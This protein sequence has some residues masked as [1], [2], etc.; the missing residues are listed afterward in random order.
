MG[1][2]LNDLLIRNVEIEG[3]HSDVRILGG[4]IAEIGPGLRSDGEVL[5]GAGGAL[6]PGLADHH[7]HLMG[8][9][10]ARCSV[11]LDDVESPGALARRLRRPGAGWLRATG[12]HENRA[13][14]L[15]RAALDRIVSDRPVRVQHQT[16][17]VWI[18][19]SAALALLDLADAPEGVDAATGRIERADAWLR[20]QI[21]QEAP[22]LA[23]LG[24]A[25][26][27]MG[28]T[29]VTD[30]SV[31]NDDAAAA[32]LAD[33]ATGGALP[34]RVTMMSGR[35]LTPRPGIAVGHVKILPDDH[36]LPTLDEMI[37]R[38]GDARRWRRGIAVHCVTAAELALTLAALETAG[39]MPGDRIEHGGVISAEAIPQLKR[40][41]LTVVTQSA[42]PYTRGDR[43]LAEVDRQEVGD[44]YRCASLLRAGVPVAGSSDAPYAT[45]DPWLAMRAAVTRRT[46]GGQAIGAGEAIDAR[47]A[48]A[49]YLGDASDPGGP[50]RRVEIGAVA[51]LCVL[52]MPVEQLSSEGVAATLVAGRIVHRG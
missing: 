9:A 32:L 28:V 11:A 48:L 14:A 4:R 2:C 16:G 41:G 24:A 34:Q 5:E 36:N 49:L 43:Y 7:I 39:A 25:L 22:D 6:I 47:A 23:Q 17:G 40:M 31:T 52:R 12:F 10:A 18:L 8:A 38:I 51:D 20:A 26:A 42:F 30:A 45:A 35:A 3:R 50:P 15:D 46:A 13:G 19:N 33:A 29:S 21:G 27:A 1:G 44:L 37:A